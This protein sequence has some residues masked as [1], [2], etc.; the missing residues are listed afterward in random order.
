MG[1][2]RGWCHQRCCCVT[3]ICREDCSASTVTT[4]ATRL[5][6]L[7]A[8]RTVR[9]MTYNMEQWLGYYLEG[10]AEEYERVQAEVEQLNRLGL[11]GSTPTQLKASQQRGLSALT[12]QGVREFSRRDYEA[13]AGVQR[14]TALDDLVSKRILSR[15]NSGPQTRYGFVRASDDNR[16][17]PRR[18]TPE[19]I[20]DELEGFCAEHDQWPSVADFKAGGNMALYL[21][22]TRYGGVDYWAERVGKSRQPS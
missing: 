18:W 14:T 8:L 4:R 15:L 6:Y 1:V 10:L 19:R 3:D 7:T 9:N 17:R 21:A 12:I 13:T 11:N 2:P 16:G 20:Q 5:L 22:V